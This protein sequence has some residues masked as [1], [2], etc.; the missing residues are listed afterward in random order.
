MVIKNGGLERSKEAAEKE[1]YHKLPLGEST[2]SAKKS[3]PSSPY[4][5]PDPFQNQ[6]KHST[7]NH[8]LKVFGTPWE[9]VKS[10]TNPEFNEKELGAGF[11]NIDRYLGNLDMK[12][13]G[14]IMR[15]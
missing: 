11:K 15:C 8:R 14:N 13:D 9:E 1:F 2:P 6:K 3:F 10:E 5:L 12:L 7:A 4:Q